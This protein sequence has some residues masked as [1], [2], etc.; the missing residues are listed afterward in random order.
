MS[1][2]ESEN[3]KIKK[4]LDAADTTLINDGMFQNP[5]NGQEANT[6]IEN[7][8]VQ[9]Y[10]SNRYLIEDGNTCE[11]NINVTESMRNFFGKKLSSIIDQTIEFVYTDDGTL[12]KKC[13]DPCGVRLLKDCDVFLQVSSNVESK[14]KFKNHKKV[15]R[16]LDKIEMKKVQL[17]A[18]DANYVA[19]KTT[20]CW[21]NRPKA[22]VYTYKG[23]N[24]NFFLQY[25][26]N[27]FTIKRR[28]NKWDESKIFSFRRS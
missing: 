7:P 4:V 1:D 11:T 24:L 8:T 28:K 10:P 21:S 27:E 25:P 20:Q 12:K 17:V 16:Q 18:V 13:S 15:R 22:I 26:A 6:G 5:I 19:H 3:D 14:T 2:T 9:C 23:E